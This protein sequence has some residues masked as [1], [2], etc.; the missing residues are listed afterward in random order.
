MPL[1]R[2]WTGTPLKL[3]QS[4]KLRYLQGK[5]QRHHTLTTR[6]KPAKAG[7]KTTILQKSSEE[8]F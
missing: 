5:R 2:L 3:V 7:T 8:M 1:E 6:A 4:A